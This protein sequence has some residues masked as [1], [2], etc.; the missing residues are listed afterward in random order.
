MLTYLVVYVVKVLTIFFGGVPFVG[1]VFACECSVAD[2][3]F[4]SGGV[5]MDF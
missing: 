1:V 5:L 3:G 2:A 4:A